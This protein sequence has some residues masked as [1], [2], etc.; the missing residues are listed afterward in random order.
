MFE[1]TCTSNLEALATGIP[2]ISTDVGDIGEVLDGFHNGIIIDNNEN[3]SELISSAVD[4]IISIWDNPPEMNNS[5]MKYSGEEVVCD[6]K[7]EIASL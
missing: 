6:L 2:I 1:G 3:E 4:A 7:K 5:F